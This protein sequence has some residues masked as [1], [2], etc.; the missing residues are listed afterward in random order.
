MP[1]NA[2]RP[3]I[4]TVGSQLVDH[5]YLQDLEAET[6]VGLCRRLV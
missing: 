3:L 2:Y 4:E 5:M 1:V 6:D